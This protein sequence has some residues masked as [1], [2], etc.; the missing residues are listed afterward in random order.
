[1]A[2]LHGD[3]RREGYYRYRG[4][5]KPDNTAVQAEKTRRLLRDSR[6]RLSFNAT[7]MRAVSV[8]LNQQL[9]QALCDGMKVTRLAA[10]AELSR[11]TVR[12]V[13]LSADD[14]VPSGVPAEE[15][16]ALIRQLKSELAEL[17]ESKTALEDRRL[18]L[19]ATARR[20]GV[21]DD[22]ELAALSGLQR[23][24]IRKMTWGIQPEAGAIPA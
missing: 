22:Y 2:V 6:Q 14:L 11:W 24:T 19:L 10:A 8:R 23:E 4:T 20:R 3:D 15:H 1:M 16:L 18:N 12:T 13:G 17:E 9:A 5:P 7:S 21:L